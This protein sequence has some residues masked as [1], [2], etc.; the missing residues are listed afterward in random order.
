MCDLS[1]AHFFFPDFVLEQLSGR[2]YLFGQQLYFIVPMLVLF[3]NESKA[4]F[5]R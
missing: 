4:I 2:F 3:E 1:F 5:V